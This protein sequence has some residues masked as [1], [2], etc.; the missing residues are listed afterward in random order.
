M[1]QLSDSNDG[2]FNWGYI[3]AVIS[4]VLFRINSRRI[5]PA[6]APE[7]IKETDHKLWKWKNTT[8]SLIHSCITGFGA[9]VKYAF[10]LLFHELFFC[11]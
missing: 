3:G 10:I 1:F 8:N 4:F 5:L 7:L 6:Y 2:S 11:K 9:I